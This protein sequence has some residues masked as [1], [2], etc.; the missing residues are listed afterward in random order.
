MPFGPNIR[1]LRSR[2]MMMSDPDNVH[3]TI[4]PMIDIIIYYFPSNACG[5]G[6]FNIVFFI[7]HHTSDHCRTDVLLQDN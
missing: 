3:Q 2:N 7:Y 1:S 6:M 4:P 5:S